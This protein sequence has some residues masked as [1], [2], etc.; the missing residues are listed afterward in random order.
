[1][2]RAEGWVAVECCSGEHGVTVTRTVLG[3]TTIELDFT[4]IYLKRVLGS[5][6]SKIKYLQVKHK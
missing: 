6:P 4:E 3:T 5:W 1:M 2:V